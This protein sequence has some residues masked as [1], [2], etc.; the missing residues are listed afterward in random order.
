MTDVAALLVT[1]QL[2]DSAFPA[3]F[4]TLSHGLE[5]YAQSKSVT[6]ET[7]PDLLV[8]LLRNSVGPSDATAV[9]LAH[10]AVRERD[11]EQ[12]RRVDRRLYATKLN[13]ELRRACTR[14]GHQMLSVSRQ[15]FGRSDIDDF[16]VE[17][18]AQRTPGTQPVVTGV[19]AAACGVEVAQAVAG[20]LFAFSSSLVGAALRLRL[21]DHLRAQ[22]I[23]ADAAPVIE[24][25]TETALHRNL[26]DIGGCTPVADVMSA[27]HERAEA[28][29]F[30]S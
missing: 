20:D 13:R 19:V 3:G 23:L 16:A 27:R 24:E 21:T 11:P 4:Y 8:D 7:L 26:D 18:R 12:L 2:T 22:R 29:L 6:P 30:V 14:T 5:G 1:L 10:A 25:V 17:V 9:A 28:R 15:T